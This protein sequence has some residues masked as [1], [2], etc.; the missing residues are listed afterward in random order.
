MIH[1]VARFTGCDRSKII[2]LG[3]PRTDAYFHMEKVETPY[4]QYLYAPTFRNG[5]WQPYWS[6][7]D[8]LMPDDIRIIAKP[9]MVSPAFDI[10]FREHITEVSNKETSAN[11]LVQT[12]GII[13]DYSSIMFDAMVLRRPIILFARDKNRYLMERGMYCQYPEMYSKYFCQD[14]ERL[15]ELMRSAEWDDYSEN[16]RQYYAGAC[17]GNSTQRV[18]DLIRSLV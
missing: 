4:K 11:Y 3:M 14:E 8:L 18:I 6:K 5:G 17:D 7:L 16:L 1:Y 2:P 10:G 13:S 9:H 15:V 12:D